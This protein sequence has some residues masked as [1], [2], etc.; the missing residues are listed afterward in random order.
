[1]LVKLHS[2]R[3]ANYFMPEVDLQ[4][5]QENSVS[6]LCLFGPKKMSQDWAPLHN[7]KRRDL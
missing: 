2:S 1:M 6:K 5:Q 3:M 7:E 4:G